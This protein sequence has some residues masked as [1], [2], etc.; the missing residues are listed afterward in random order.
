MRRAHRLVLLVLSLSLL[1]GA[2]V[3]QS[4][5]AVLATAPPRVAVL[6]YHDV[7]VSPDSPYTITPQRL[8][9]DLTWFKS[10]GWRPLTLAAF[11]EWMEGRRQ[12]SG[13]HFLLTFDDGYASLQTEVAPLLEQL[14][15]P[16]VSFVITAH[17]GPV[18]PT[19]ER[20]KLTPAAIRSLARGG[21]VSFGSHTHDLHRNTTVAGAT[22]PLVF[23]T[24]PADLAADLSASRA[25]L[26]E[27]TG[28]APTAL[29]WPSGQAPDWAQRRAAEQF[30]FQFGG[31][32]GFVHQGQAQLIPRFAME[33]RTPRDLE[34][35]FR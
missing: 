13:D 31:N 34:R 15:V 9:A 10:R 11:E 22:R 27:L 35:S 17:I 20:P 7:A 33:W 24:T 21:L 12:L 1:T 23:A 29:A 26:A 18:D 2:W 4:L 8:A 5:Q 19:K 3:W 25:R 30:A 28:T 6:T 16:A 14:L 32:D